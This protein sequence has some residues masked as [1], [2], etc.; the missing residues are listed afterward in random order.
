MKK[1]FLTAILAVCMFNINAQPDNG[2]TIV[3]TRKVAPNVTVN[4][5]NPPAVCESTGTAIFTITAVGDNPAYQWQV[6]T[7]G[8]GTWNN[9]TNVA[10]YSG[11]FTNTL[12]VT[13]PTASMNNYQYR[14]VVSGDCTPS[15]TSLAAVLTINMNPAITAQPTNTT[16]CSG[17]AASFTTVATGFNLS[18]QWQLLTGAIW[19]DIAPDA[20]YQNTATATL[21][22]TNSLGLN[23]KQYRCK[24]T[25]GCST[26]IYTAAVTLTV[27]DLPAVTSDPVNPPAICSGVG[28]AT[29][30]VGATGTGIAYQWQ[31]NG[32]NIANGAMPS[33]GTCSGATSA[34]LTL[35]NPTSALNGNSYQCVVSGTCAPSATSLPATLTVNTAPVVTMSANDTIC[36]YSA[37]SFTAT[38]GTPGA[39]YVWKINI[40]AGF[41]T[42]NNGTNTDGVVITNATTN[43]IDLDVVPLTYNAST[44]EAIVT[45][46][47]TTCSTT[48]STAR[49]VVRALPTKYA[50]K[51][52]GASISVVN[53]TLRD[54]FC[55]VEG[56]IVASLVGSQS[57]VLYEF[58]DQATQSVLDTHI[59]APAGGAF[60]F[61]QLPEGVYEIWSIKTYG[62]LTCQRKQ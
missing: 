53:D 30:T 49:I 22:I 34:T 51:L 40:G 20:T 47:A 31:E 39:T 4:P 29:F 37:T 26:P 6:S 1:F 23:T 17:S 25:G 7:D 14:C 44:I 45:D 57:G 28:T 9:L 19:N 11:V 42:L 38:T 61:I 5:T 3:F 16:V 62:T 54:T 10:P 35:T 8:G 50:I 24:I 56:G 58:R 21:N 43:M 27:Q 52:D 55:P 46:P 2:T 32:I 60:S 48:S 36:E 41:V 15:S 13:S 12:T 59:G 33:G 18:Y